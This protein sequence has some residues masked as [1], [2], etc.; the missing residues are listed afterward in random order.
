MSLCLFLLSLQQCSLGIF[1]WLA[2]SKWTAGL[3]SP[4]ACMCTRCTLLCCVGLGLVHVCACAALYLLKV[5]L[6]EIKGHVT[7]VGLQFT[8]QSAPTTHLE[9]TCPFSA[10]M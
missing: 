5:I 8:P 4:P 6:I 10:R 1:L 7:W 9:I 2:N 3:Q